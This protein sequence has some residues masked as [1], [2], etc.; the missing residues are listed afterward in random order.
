M[1]ENL[2]YIRYQC[3]LYAMSYFIQKL[4][5][6]KLS[7]FSLATVSDAAKETLKSKLGL[8]FMQKNPLPTETCK[9]DEVPPLH[10]NLN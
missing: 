4:E 7:L 5:V 3:L 2:F 1:R 9:N 10:K 6:N 8:K